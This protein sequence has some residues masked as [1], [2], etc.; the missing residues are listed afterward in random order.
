MYILYDIDLRL[1]LMITGRLYSNI[2]F[3]LNMQ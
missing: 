2:F 1:V 3:I